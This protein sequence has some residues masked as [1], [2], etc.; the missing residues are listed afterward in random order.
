MMQFCIT[1]ECRWRLI[2]C[3]DCGS[4]G[5]LVGEQTDSE[6]C[7][8]CLHL[9]AFHQKEKQKRQE[10]WDKVRPVSKDFPKGADGNDLPYLYPGD[11]AV[12]AP[13]HPVVTIKKNHY[14]DKKMRQECI[15]LIQDPVPVW[16]KVLPSTCLNDRFM[17]IERCVRDDR[18]YTVANAQRV[19]QWLDFLFEHHKDFVRLEAIKQLEKNDAYI[20]ALTP[21]LELAEVDNSS[22]EYTTSQ[23]KELERQM[24]ENDDG[25]TDATV[26]SGFS[27]THVF[28]F[29]RYEELYLKT[30]DVLRIRKEGKIEI[31]EDRT[32]REPTYCTSANLAFPYLF[33][34]GELSPLDLGDYKLARFVLEKTGFICAQH[35]RRETAIYFFTKR[36]LFS[37]SVRSSQRAN[38]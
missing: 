18:K 30:R 24:Q 11:K 6:V 35:E 20:D 10:A 25:I 4:C 38:C 34:Y 17:V 32:I 8:D 7:Y 13:V 31:I 22:A 5:I 14:A 2:E 36:H 3:P 27:E 29:D 9:S 1:E 12:I 37:P 26:E 15:T 21:D 33:P 16:S 23:A 28:T 19:C